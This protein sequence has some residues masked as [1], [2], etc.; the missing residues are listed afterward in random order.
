[1]PQCFP[2]SSL[3]VKFIHLLIFLRILSM[4]GGK[5]VVRN[6]GVNLSLKFEILLKFYSAIFPHINYIEKFALCKV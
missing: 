6:Y 2:P 4:S 1:M 3:N 5:K